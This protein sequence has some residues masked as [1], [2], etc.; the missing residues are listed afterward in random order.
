MGMPRL[1]LNAIT[2]GAPDP[3]ALA[4]FYARLLGRTVTTASEPAPGEPPEAGWAQIASDGPGFALNFEY[5]RR[6]RAPV[7]PAEPDRP[8]ATQH[9]DV[10]VDDLD[11]AVAH[12]VAQGATLAETQ[13]QSDVRVLF[14]P[15]G[16]PFCLYL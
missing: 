1:T 6:W 13:P 5:E 11:A 16:H 7:W 10:Q 2:I 14:D 3:L 8:F 4:D 9:L 15:A 12:A